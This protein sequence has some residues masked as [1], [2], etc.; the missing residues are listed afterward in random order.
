MAEAVPTPDAHA[1]TFVHVFDGIS[2]WR[3]PRPGMTMFGSHV[4]RLILTT[5]RL[6]FLSTGS[7]G[8]GRAFA[9]SAL[10]GPVAMLTVG[11]TVTDE[12]DLGALR[13]EGGLSLPLDHVTAARVH[14]R[15]DFSTY[16]TVETAGTGA[17]PRACSFMTRFGQDGP[18]IRALHERLEWAPARIADPASATPLP[19]SFQPTGASPAGGGVVAIL[20]VASLGATVYRLT[21]R[22]PRAERRAHADAAN[23]ERDRLFAAVGVP[24]EAKPLGPATGTAARGV[25]PIASIQQEFERPGAW[26]DTTAWYRARLTRDGWSAVERLRAV[27]FCRGEWAVDVHLIHD[28]SRELPPSHRFRTDLGWMEG[29]AR[30]TPDP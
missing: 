11:Q 13:N 7:S 26:E 20:V 8:M 5:R 12:L 28:W 29:P 24:P 3:A 17:Y 21:A 16:L 1:E 19:A 14:R 23:A 30:C 2:A 18:A 22:D 10:G 27:R 25:I 9:S 4:G 15:W 6:L